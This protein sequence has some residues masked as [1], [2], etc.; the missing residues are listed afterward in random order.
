MK[1]WIIIV[2]YASAP[3]LMLHFHACGAMGRCGVVG[4][5]VPLLISIA[6]LQVEHGTCK[7]GCI[8]LL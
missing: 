5:T 2:P 8:S 7:Q 1:I 4:T 6:L 3:W